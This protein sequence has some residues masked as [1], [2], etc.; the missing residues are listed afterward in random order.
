MPRRHALAA[1]VA[2]A[3]AG[4]GTG[5]LP[6]QAKGGEDVP[7][8]LKDQ[9]IATA[10]APIEGV[11]P[12]GERVAV[13]GLLNKRNG[14]SQD[15][16][17]KPGEARRIGDAVVQLR[18][19]ET[20]AP[21]ES[22]PETGAF[23]RLFSADAKGAMQRRFSGWLFKNRPE[24]NVVIHP[25]YDV[26]VK[27]CAMRFPGTDAAA[28]D[29]DSSASSAPKSADANGSGGGNAPPVPPAPKPE[30]AKPPAAAPSEPDNAR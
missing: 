16:E 24:R 26:Y 7:E 30:A 15:I 29:A 6:D 8:A 14:L 5:D 3:L 23:V 13:L 22:P 4:C 28:P 20:T 9:K 11:T 10:A 17:I 1:G 27:S 21:W 12:M 25:I 18:A 19:C 2:L